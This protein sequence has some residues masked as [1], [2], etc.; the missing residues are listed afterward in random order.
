[1]FHRAL[2]TSSG[3]IRWEGTGSQQLV[4]I[5]WVVRGGEERRGEERRGED[6]GRMTTIRTLTSSFRFGGRVSL[7]FAF[8]T[9]CNAESI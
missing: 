6:R 2:S 1:M 8:A 4:I 7:Y 5:F 9:A 3:V